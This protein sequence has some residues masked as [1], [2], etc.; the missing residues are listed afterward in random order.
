M[1]I[2]GVDP[3]L[4]VGL[5]VLDTEFPLVDQ[6]RQWTGQIAG[7]GWEREV[8]MAEE[9][10]NMVGEHQVDAICVEDFILRKF[11]SMARS[12][13]SPVRITAMMDALLV[14]QYGD[15]YVGV[16]RNTVAAFRRKVRLGEP[17]LGRW[18]ASAATAKTTFTDARLQKIGLWKGLTTHERDAWRH[19]LTFCKS[20]GIVVK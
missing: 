19:V 13:L 3:G 12:G 6:V 5:C 4:H 14:S 8:A 9:I 2:L 18:C 15:E 7:E 20:A 10:V 16:N 17:V 11:G 1:K